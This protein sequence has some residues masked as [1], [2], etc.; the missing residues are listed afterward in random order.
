MQFQGRLIFDLFIGKGLKP[1]VVAKVHKRRK[2]ARYFYKGWTQCGKVFII[3]CMKI[4]LATGNEHKKREMQRIFADFQIV[5]PKDENI[6]FNPEETGSTF[7]ENSLIKAKALWS[8]VKKPVIADDSGICV[9]ALGGE[10]GIFSSRYGG[11]AFPHGLPDGK[12]MP[13]AEQNRQL[14]RQVNKVTDFG[15]LPEA[16]YLNGERSC[17]YS[18]A[19]VCYFGHEQFFAAQE[20]MEGSLIERIEDAAGTGGFGYDPLVI[21]PKY[22]KTVAELTD[23]QKDEISHRG[24]AS[25]ALYGLAKSVLLQGN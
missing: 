19:L 5:I 2:S 12:K 22:G 8:I 3:Q 25:R 7:F 24:K 17:H 21:I 11:L 16:P 20:T 9:D 1:I 18:C 10:P 14:I 15:M 6:D 23:E 13:Q 4:Y